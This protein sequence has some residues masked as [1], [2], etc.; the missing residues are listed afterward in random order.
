[1]YT[2]GFGTSAVESKTMPRRAQAEFIG[3]RSSHQSRRRSVSQLFAEAEPLQR[4][5]K[6][7][8]ASRA[9]AIFSAPASAATCC[10]TCR[11]AA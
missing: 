4:Q 2:A 5:N 11:K 6:L 1:M 7:D 10:S 3:L 8:D 9:S